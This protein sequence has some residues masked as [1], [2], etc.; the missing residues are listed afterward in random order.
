MLRSIKEFRLPDVEEKVLQFWRTNAIFKKTQEQR[1]GAKPFVFYEGPPTANAAPA[2]HHVLARSF[3]DVVLRY[4][5]MR[6]Y[7]VPR[8]AGWDTHGLPVELQVEK[9]LG[10]SSKKEI[11]HLVPDSVRDSIK[12]FNEKCRASVWQFTQEWRRLTERIAFW[13]DLDDP[14]ITY[15]PT[16]IESLWWV[17]ARARKKG[18]FYKGYKVVPWCPRCG[19]ALSSH[20]LA[21]G[22]KEAEDVSVYVRFKLLPDQEL[23]VTPLNDDAYILSWTTTPWTLPG[24]VALAV[25]NDAAYAIVL[26]SYETGDVTYILAA[27]RVDAVMPAV[28]HAAPWRVLKTVRGSDLVGLRYV[29]LFDVEPLRNAKSHRV[30]PADF[31]TTNDGTGV[32]HTAV[33]YGEDDYQLGT[34]IGLPQIHTVDEAG[35]FTDIVPGLAGL[36]VKSKHAEDA[37]LHAL[38]GNGFLAATEK[39]R[40]EYPFCWRCSTPLLYYA[41]HS[42]F[43]A[44]SKR[45]GT[46]AAENEKINWHP[47]HLKNGRFGEWVRDAK[48]WAFSRERY[49]GT[50]LP[51]WE[52]AQGHVRV[53]G[54]LKELDDAAY[55]RNAIYIARHP[56]AEANLKGVFATG[57][58]SDRAHTSL[59]TE[60]GIAKAHAM[61]RILKR[62]HI[63]VIYA[64]PYARTRQ[65]AEIVQKETGAALFFDERLREIEGGAFAWRPVSEHKTFF[66]NPLEEF[67]KA[68]EGGE[69]LGAVK[70]RMFAAL[71]DINAKYADTRILIISHGDPLWMLEAAV[72]GH[73]NE[74]ALRS[75]YVHLGD[76]RKLNLHN[77]PYND[78]GELD[79]HRP[80]IDDITIRCAEC[81]EEMKRVKEIADVWFDS[82]A[83]PFASVHYPFGHSWFSKFPFPADYICEAID[84]TRGWFYTLLAVA[85]L[86]GHGRPF[87]NV[88]SLGY[89]HDK[90][91]LKMSK[92]K[93]NV[94]DPW[95]M[96]NTYGADAIRWHFFTINAPGDTKNFD[97]AE[98]AKTLR[99]TVLILYNSFAFLET[100][101]DPP[102]GGKQGAVPPASDNVLD[103][104]ILA[105]LADTSA[106]ATARMERYEITEAARGLEEFIDDLSRWYIRR[107]RK[108]FS[109]KEVRQLAEADRTRAIGTLSYV[110]FATSRLLAPFMPLFAEALHASVAIAGKKE[111]V[112]LEDWPA[113][114]RGDAKLIGQMAAVRTIVADGLAARAVAS[115]KVRQPLATL[116]V[117]TDGAGLAKNADL[118]DVIAEEVNV[119]RVVFD[120]SITEPVRLDTA[121]TPE[122]REEGIVR[123]FVRAVQGL[124][125]KA[126]LHPRD[127]IVIVADL[128]AFLKEILSERAALIV[129]DVGATE[130]RFHRKGTG[131]DVVDAEADMEMEDREIWIAIKKLR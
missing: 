38:K 114:G 43:M 94:V 86:V 5:T 109:L 123:E 100:Y 20:E 115:V 64:S 88:I 93:G 59:L 9:A 129:K 105:R 34:D 117:K 104:W 15:E 76:I 49:W 79:L 50:P 18:L 10:I 92:S 33:M 30:Y 31:V 58:E 14:Y 29:Q 17:I 110:L 120:P 122:L 8:R 126:G 24:N 125:Q 113:G 73:S 65:L 60:H 127:R 36:F 40:H 23:N 22:Y 75:S 45:R 130:L 37:V 46:L 25:A 47:E 42:W 96:I 48:D 63:T 44:M 52:C 35:K 66:A 39:Y 68:P 56:E 121:I 82:G 124:R 81:R 12:L 67:T 7:F 6:G 97:E 90:V 51:V 19:T 116:S 2:L 41:R 128:P 131:A 3:K 95:Q 28:V 103:R 107:S 84:Q 62:K 89:L 4:K 11:E 85:V 70:R 83:M 77:W 1:K 80:Y 72:A 71:R 32:V 69:S 98:L 101:G 91:G 111:S 118:L 74:E 55:A 106:A 119:K 78:D 112:H 108:R 27:D 54:A 53:V 13:L 57:P 87:R 26:V 99:R 21:Q 16:Y 102:A 61:A